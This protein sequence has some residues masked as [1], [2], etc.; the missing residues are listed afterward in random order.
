MSNGNLDE[1]DDELSPTTAYPPWKEALRLFLAE[2]FRPGDII[3][4]RWFWNAFG[5]EE[6][7]PD[8]RYDRGEK[9]RLDYVAQLDPLRK[10]LLMDHRIDLRS[11][12]G[13]GYLWVEPGEQTSKAVTDGRK[14]LNKAFRR[15]GSRL[16][17]VQSEMLTDAQKLENAQELARLAM[18]TSMVRQARRL[19][20]PDIEE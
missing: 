12:P 8:W 15:Y 2:P 9:A 7:K 10:A 6:P 18:Q 11:E 16:L 17:H 20:A 3:P 14:E 5:L 1:E 4:H 19:P 13:E